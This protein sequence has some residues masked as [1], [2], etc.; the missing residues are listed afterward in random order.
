MA[1]RSEPNFDAVTALS[2][3]ARDHQEDAVVADF[4][5]GGDLGLIVL[6]DGMGG[7]AAGDVASKIVMTEVFSELKLQASN[8]ET[9]RRGLPEL[10]LGA[11]TAAND[12]IRAH[13]MENPDA[14]GMGATLIA[15][16]MNRGRLN[17]ISIGDSPLFLYRDGTLSQLNEDHSMAPQIDFMVETGLM[18]PETAV[19]HPDRNC[20]TS[21]LAGDEIAKI[22]CPEQ[23]FALRDGDIVIAASDGLQ[24]LENWE[25]SKI[26]KG[27]VEDPSKEIA[28]HFLDE[29][30]RIDDPDQDNVS[31][32]VVKVSLPDADV[33]ALDATRVA[34][35][36]L[37][38]SAEAAAEGHFVRPRR[39]APTRLVHAE[40][41]R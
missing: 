32:V 11:A 36:P 30:E 4:P 16:V 37:R 29:L 26:L 10:L 6:S 3:G 41:R 34:T 28:R 22:D 5:L 24:F 7:H 2:L 19:D 20:L 23:S 40:A 31:I 35:R 17:W 13:I 18:D 1:Q 8:P 12:C 9:L 25:I 33:H 38:D 14:E 27:R 39:V 21:V 15:A